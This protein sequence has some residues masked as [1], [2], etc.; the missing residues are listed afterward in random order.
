MASAAT[1]VVLKHWKSVG[2]ARQRRTIGLLSS[3]LR[4]DISILKTPL[5]D[6]AEAFSSSF[7]WNPHLLDPFSILFRCVAIWVGS[8]KEVKYKD[9]EVVRDELN[10][11]VTMFLCFC[12]LVSSPDNLKLNFFKFCSCFMQDEDRESPC[13]RWTNVQYMSL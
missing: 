13:T 2:S 6:M 9:Q 5:T 10:M 11:C 12:P 7:P 4:F 1:G 3:L 8:S